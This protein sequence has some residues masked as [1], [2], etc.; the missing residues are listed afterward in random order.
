MQ[1]APAGGGSVI[2]NQPLEAALSLLTNHNLG[3]PGCVELQDVLAYLNL[4]KY[5]DVF[6]KQ[7]VGL[8]LRVKTGL[9]I[10]QRL[11]VN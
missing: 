8:P 9:P 2:K 5:T 6:R 11:P 10:I 4:D 1:K 3:G 7:E